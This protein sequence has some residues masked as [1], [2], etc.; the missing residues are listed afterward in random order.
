MRIILELPSDARMRVASRAVVHAWL[1]GEVPRQILG[2]AAAHGRAVPGTRGRAFGGSAVDAGEVLGSALGLAREGGEGEA[3][4]A[5]LGAAAGVGVG[6]LIRTAG[7][8]SRGCASAG[9]GVAG[10]VGGVGEGVEAA[11]EEVVVGAGEG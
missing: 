6:I 7:V 2:R 1:F 8:V 10:A 9:F 11:F 4:E 5:L 3:R